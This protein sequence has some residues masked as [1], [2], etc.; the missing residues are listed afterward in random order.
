MKRI[1][2]IIPIIAISVLTLSAQ[3]ATRPVNVT[4]GATGS[5]SVLGYNVQRCTVPSGGATCTPSGAALN[6]S[7]LVTGLSFT[8]SAVPIGNSVIYGVTAVYPVCTGTSSLTVPCGTAAMA[9]SGLVPV[10]PQGPGAGS[11]IVVVP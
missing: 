9:N 8:D 6:G 5:S 3:A 1:I 2:L 11:V 10:P 4:W 7:T